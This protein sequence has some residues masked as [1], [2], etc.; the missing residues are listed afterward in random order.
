[1]PNFVDLFA[2]CGGLS[3]GLTQAGWTGRFA[4]EHHPDAFE[5]LRSNLLTGRTKRF[6]WPRWLEQRPWSIQDLLAEHERDLAALRGSITLTT[7]GPPCQGYSTAGRRNPKDS[8]N[9]LVKH[10]LR[11][12][13]L[14]AP[15]FLLLE[16]VVGFTTGFRVEGRD[17]A[18]RR[19]RAASDDLAK[20]LD[21]LGYEVRSDILN[22]ADWGVPQRR[23]RFIAMAVRRGVAVCRQANDLMAHFKQHRPLF[24]S[25]LGLPTD[26][27]VTTAEALDDLRTT[28]RNRVP[29]P[30]H[31]RFECV[32]YQAVTQPTGYLAC[33][34][35]GM[36]DDTPNSLR[37]PKHRPATAARFEQILAGQV[38][39]RS[40]PPAKRQEYGMK[41]HTFIPLAADMPSPTMTT[42]PDDF[43]HYS[44]PRILTVREMAR[45]QSFPDWYRFE[46]KYTTGGPMRAK[47]CPR[48]TQVGNA[49]PPLLSRALGAALLDARRRGRTRRPPA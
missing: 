27:H 9:K 30:D 29:D 23:L 14:V 31:P 46:G 21:E 39:G 2:G 34:R 11:F 13:E 40:L 18:E 49:V 10:Y 3:L 33:V 12:V 26:R 8:R 28:G 16:N 15:D 38:R 17:G 43:L 32:D 36:G 37:L 20:S 25:A 1:M 48:Y 4:V 6:V 19:T 22:C 35:N 5:T 45:L 44:E 42:L 41:K 7:G 47:D 24:L